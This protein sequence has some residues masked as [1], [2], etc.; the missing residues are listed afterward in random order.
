[1]AN[2]RLKNGAD[3]GCKIRKKQSEHGDNLPLLAQKSRIAKRFVSAS[4]ETQ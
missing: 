1:M 2:F 4:C 3:A